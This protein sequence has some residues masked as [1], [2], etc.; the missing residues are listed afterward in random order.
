MMLI[1][2]E[3]GN[4]TKSRVGEC[5]VQRG[6]HRPAALEV[7]QGNAEDESRDV[8]GED[9]DEDVLQGMTRSGAD[10]VGVDE[11]VMLLVNRAVHGGDFVGDAV[12]P[13]EV[14]V[15]GKVD[16]HKLDRSEVEGL[17]DGAVG[18]AET[19]PAKATHQIVHE[20]V[21]GKDGDDAADA[22]EA[23][24][25]AV[26]LVVWAI[27]HVRFGMLLRLPRALGTTVVVVDVRDEEAES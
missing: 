17:A 11:D 25:V 2:G 12:G 18:R 1:V 16:A 9:V 5:G 14:D 15:G 6:K 13:V 10:G 3:T 20:A 4:P 21:H 8:D 27:G 19:I 26:E 24:S 23:N 22:G 7:E